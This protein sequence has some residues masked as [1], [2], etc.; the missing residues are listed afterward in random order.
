M[1]E[2]AIELAKELKKRNNIKYEGPIIGTIIKEFPKLKIEIYKGEVILDLKRLYFTNQ[3]LDH[4]KNIN[5]TGHITID[6]VT[7]SYESSDEAA[8]V[9]NL[10]LKDKVLLIPDCDGQVFYLIDTVRKLV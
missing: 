9:S 1:T 2:Y 7:S 4:I 3:V 8:F 5:R 6:G 10:K